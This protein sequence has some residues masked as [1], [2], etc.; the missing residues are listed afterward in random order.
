MNLYTNALKNVGVLNCLMLRF[1]PSI[2]NDLMVFRSPFS[3][4]VPEELKSRMALEMASEY[5]AKS[6]T[7]LN[8]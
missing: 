4:V 3:T 7:R 6:G 1:K 2:F 8:E 5:D